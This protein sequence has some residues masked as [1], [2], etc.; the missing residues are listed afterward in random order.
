M[1]G[2]GGAD[3]LAGLSGNDVL[4]AGAGTDELQ[5]GSG[6]DRL[7]AGNDDGQRDDLYDGF[8]V[9]TV[10]G[11]TEDFFHRCPDGEF[12]DVDQFHGTTVDEPDC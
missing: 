7:L 1:V 8:G 6:D 10:I 11:D 2:N 9:D 4:N 3:T 5:G 12:D